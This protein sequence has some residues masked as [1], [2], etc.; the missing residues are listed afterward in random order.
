ML[1]GHIA[2]KWLY[3]LESSKGRFLCKNTIDQTMENTHGFIYSVL[4]NFL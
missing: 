3:E 4:S 1:V 2:A